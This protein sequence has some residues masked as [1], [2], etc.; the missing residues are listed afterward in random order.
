[1]LKSTEVL[2]KCYLQFSASSSASHL[3]QT[4]RFAYFVYSAI[5]LCDKL[6]Y[7]EY[8]SIPLE[9]FVSA[10]LQ[11][12]LWISIYLLT[13]NMKQFEEPTFNVDEGQWCKIAIGGKSNNLIYSCHEVD[14]TSFGKSYETTGI[15]RVASDYTLLIK[16]S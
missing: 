6:N 3:H 9:C 13:M 16:L 7:R 5:F 1:M 10:A 14:A 8:N 15:S 12:L 2:P 11:K 4:Y